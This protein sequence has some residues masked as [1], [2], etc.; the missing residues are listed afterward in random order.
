MSTTSP[1]GLETP[2]ALLGT[3]VLLL[4]GPSPARLRLFA[5]LRD[6]GAH[7]RCAGLGA[8]AIS[9]GRAFRPELIVAVETSYAE[10]DRVVRDLHAAGSPGAAVVIA[11]RDETAGL[12]ALLVRLREGSRRD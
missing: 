9:S 4:G 5:L 11:S 1:V 3:R 10:C 12:A 2:P 8:E 6:A 7:V